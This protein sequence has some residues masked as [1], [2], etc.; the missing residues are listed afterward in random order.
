MWKSTSVSG[1]LVMLFTK[2]FLDD[3]AAVGSVGEEPVPPRRRTRRVDGVEVDAT[4]RKILISTQVHKLVAFVACTDDFENQPGVV[5]GCSDRVP[6]NR[7]RRAR[8]PFGGVVRAA[9]R[10]ARR[11]RGVVEVEGGVVGA[12]GLY[13]KLAWV[14]QG[15]WFDGARAR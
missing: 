12:R 8:A 6:W 4:R 5:N 3:D 14:M 15:D 10:R 11:D 9:P 2:S 1:A 7:P 13:S